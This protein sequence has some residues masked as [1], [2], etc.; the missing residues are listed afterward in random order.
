MKFKLKLVAPS[1][2]PYWVKWSRFL[3]LLRP[4]DLD[5]LNAE[6]IYPYLNGL[7]FYKTA[8]DP[9][10][11]APATI[12]IEDGHAFFVNGRHRCLLLSQYADEVPMAFTHIQPGNEVILTQIVSRPIAPDEEVELPD[13]QI[14]GRFRS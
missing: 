7:W 9:I 5:D 6:V 3:L 12:Y 8:N 11:F 4:Q 1:D 2:R 13:L 14:R 10:L